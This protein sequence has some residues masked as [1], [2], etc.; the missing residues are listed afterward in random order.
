MLSGL[1]PILAYPV[2]VLL[3]V[4]AVMN[5]LQEHYFRSIHQVL[6][7]LA[8]LGAGYATARA[9]RRGT[10]PGSEYLYM[11]FL[12]LGLAGVI[13]I[14]G[15]QADSGDGSLVPGIVII[16]AAVAGAISWVVAHRPTIEGERVEKPT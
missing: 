7:A 9:R 5:V 15:S 8:A 16:L 10:Q 14:V 11:F 13:Q 3:L 4:V 12:P 2:G 6:L 1:S